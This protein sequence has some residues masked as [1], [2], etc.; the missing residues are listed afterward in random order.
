MGHLHK[1]LNSNFGFQTLVEHNFLFEIFFDSLVFLG[2][3]STPVCGI[4][5]REC[6]IFTLGNLIPFEWMFSE[7][8]T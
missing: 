8:D 2:E 5:M 3:I 7:V 6:V 1:T 4:G